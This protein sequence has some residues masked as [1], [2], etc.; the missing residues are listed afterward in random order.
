ME[1]ENEGPFP[2]TKERR[3]GSG[4][5]PAASVCSLELLSWWPPRCSAH[6]LGCSVRPAVRFRRV[7]LRDLGMLL[8]WRRLALHRGTMATGVGLHEGRKWS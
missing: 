7:F 2:G 8:S 4:P 6:A 1:A 5:G 3:R